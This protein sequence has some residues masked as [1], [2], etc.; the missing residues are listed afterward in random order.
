MTDILAQLLKQ[1]SKAELEKVVLLV[2]GRVFPGVSEEN[3][4]VS[5]KLVVKALNVAY[6]HDTKTVEK[7]W[8]ETGDL[9]DVAAKLATKKKQRTLVSHHLTVK[10]V[11]D[12]LRKLPE[13]SGAGST[14]HKIKAVAELLSDASPMEARYITRT[15]LGALR[16]GIGEGTLRDA[17]AWAFLKLPG[18]Y[19]KDSG[20]Y[21]V[22]GDER[23]EYND[24]V[25]MV[26]KAYDMLN[27]FALVAVEAKENGVKG[28][29]K[30]ELTPGI[31][32]K[33]MLCQ[34][35]KTVE[36]AFERVGKPAVFEFKYD[37]FRIQVHKKGDNIQLFTRRLDEVTKQFPDVVKAVK[38]HVKGRDFILDGEAVGYDPKTKQYLPFQNV[39]QR[40]KRK[41]GI[42]GMAKEW[43]VEYAIFDVL[44]YN[45]E[46]L[47]HEEQQA[48]RKVLDKAV[49]EKEYEITLSNMLV[50]EG[51]KKAEKFFEDSLR[52][53]QEGLIAKSLDSPYQP[54]N[55]VGFQVKIKGILDP[56]DLVI[57]GAEWGEGKRSGWLTSL[58][59][60]CKHRGKF[61]E[62]GKVG[63]GLKEKAGMGG[64]TF[65]E[66]TKLLKPL[67][68]EEKGRYVHVKPKVVISV[69]SEEIQKS[70]T[71][72]AGYALRFPRVVGL[73]PDRGPHDVDTLSSIER[74]Y[75][76][77]RGR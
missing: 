5:D 14:D 36:E 75:K 69:L 64:P 3:L 31:P 65:A 60:A 27:D 33:S 63:T 29:G 46:S 37:G 53:G 21:E 19:N 44:Y 51:V 52:D 62:C 59:L 41:H 17:I 26:G 54:G 13:M 1:A 24:L 68:T 48:R 9:G 72:E 38:A 34:K 71:Y 49:K 2:Q 22:S 4:G 66:V 76:T 30:V 55:R 32:L 7:L 47:L 61:L 39:S 10:R 6:G 57:V 40:I 15:V 28:L 73:R 74:E 12:S 77:Q 42:E 45:G 11:Y 50:T 20:K 43:P 58:T 8:K 25:K 23:K 56:L 35:V 16:L 70:P 18:K 67:I